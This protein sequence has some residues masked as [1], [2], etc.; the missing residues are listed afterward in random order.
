M[1]FMYHI[2]V[3]LFYNR[4]VSLAFNNWHLFM[5]EN[6]IFSMI[7]FDYWSFV[8]SND[9]GLFFISFLNNRLIGHKY[10]L[11]RK[12]I[13]LSEQGAMSVAQ[14]LLVALVT[15]QNIRSSVKMAMCVA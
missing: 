3:M 7:S 12:L 9:C 6:Y 4:L 13:V 5:G 11:R 2:S 10:V 15:S 1:M 8:M 14:T